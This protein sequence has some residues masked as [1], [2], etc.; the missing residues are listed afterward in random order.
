LVLSRGF[1]IAVL[2][3]AAL[4]GAADRGAAAAGSD[5]RGRIEILLPVPSVEPRPNVADLGMP[6]PRHTV[7]RRQSVVYLE[8]APRGAFERDDRR[9]RMDQRDEAFVPRV[10]A[11]PVGT[12]VD[13]PNSDPIY[14]NVFSLSRTKSFDLG[15]YA[16]GRSKAVR[17]D[18]PGIVRVFCDIHSHMSAFI[19]VFAHRY[20]AVTD[21]EGRYRI[22]DVPPGTYAVSVWN[23]V[24][25]RE[26][27]SVT[28]PATSE[29]VEL[30]FV[31]GR[32]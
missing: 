30:N 9:A 23:E 7:D 2:A 28:V 26:T 32:R 18:R 29:P 5:I 1:S 12:T 10:L 20:F 4:Q 24:L 31:L 11:I 25:P 6:P 8:S 19:L 17:F 21:A 3:V 16:S 22:E 14:H 15:R 13:F 27:R